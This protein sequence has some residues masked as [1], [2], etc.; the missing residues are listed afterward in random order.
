MTQEEIEIRQD[1]IDATVEKYCLIL[2]NDT[3]NDWTF[4]VTSLCEV[5]HLTSD[6][7]YK[8]MLLAHTVGNSVVKHGSLGEMKKLHSGLTLRNLT[9]TIESVTEISKN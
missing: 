1:S 9:T 2:W 5:C 6:E 7:G 3:I 4:V 8:L